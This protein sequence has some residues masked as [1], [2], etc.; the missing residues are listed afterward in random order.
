MLKREINALVPI[1]SDPENADRTPEEIA[2]SLIRALDA[3]RADHNRLA[4]V[5]RHRWGVDGE[6]HM[7]V[8]GPVGVRAMAEAH[9][10]GQA[11]A[12][13]LAHSGDGRYALVPAYPNPRAAWQAIKPPPAAEVMRQRLAAEIAAYRPSGD[14]WDGE[15]PPPTCC[16]GLSSGNPCRVH[17]K[18]V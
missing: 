2:E 10:L 7:A 14:P 3:V 13:T 16:C 9:R 1:L 6:Y 12:T 11:A 5:V 17:P 4:V 8:L 18:A 15:M